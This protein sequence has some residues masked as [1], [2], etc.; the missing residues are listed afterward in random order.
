MRWGQIF[1]T[2]VLSAL[3]AYTVVSATGAGDV[4]S[5]ESVSSAHQRIA[6]IQTIRCAYAVASGLHVVDPNTGQ[7]SGIFYEL[8]EEIGR[9]LNKKIIW[10]EEVSYSDIGAG[11]AAGRYDMFCSALWH[12]STRAPAQLLSNP[13]YL[14]PVYA[15]VSPKNAARVPTL[16]ALNNSDLVLSVAEGDATEAMAKSRLPNIKTQSV[17]PLFTVG[18]YIGQVTTGHAGVILTDPGLAHDFLQQ[19]P[20]SIV[21]VGDKPVVIFPT[22]FAFAVGEHDLKAMIDI[23]VRELQHDGTTERLLQKYNRVGD[24]L[25]VPRQY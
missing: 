14:S 24:I 18:Q 8:M 19:N 20:N 4:R 25:P 22:G 13:V 21:P 12:A 16:E 10:A 23:A 3:V 6:K 17:P 11:F 15:W 9:R 2:A 1:G 5:H 7:F